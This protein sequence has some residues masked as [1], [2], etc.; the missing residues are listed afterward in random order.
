M[1]KTTNEKLAELKIDVKEFVDNPYQ[2]LMRKVKANL[3]LEEGDS[4]EWLGDVLY[5]LSKRLCS[6]PRDVVDGQFELI[7]GYYSRDEIEID[8]L[9]ITELREMEALMGA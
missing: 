6:N 2:A 4:S 5:E 3:K 1:F 8:G 7:E 9:T